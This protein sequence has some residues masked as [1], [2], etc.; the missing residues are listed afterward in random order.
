LQT[1]SGN[2]R[3]GIFRFSL[4]RF[5]NVR[6]FNETL[7]TD[8]YIQSIR[9]GYFMFYILEEEEEEEENI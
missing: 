7:K 5:N 2:T 6:I 4:P 8:I 9:R 1:P 3:F